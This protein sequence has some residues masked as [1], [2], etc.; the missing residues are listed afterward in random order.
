MVVWYRHPRFGAHGDK[1]RDAAG[2]ERHQA[3]VDNKSDGKF[4]VNHL[5]K[6]SNGGAIECSPPTKC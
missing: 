3:K 2:R 6:Q 4:D 5:S 1:W